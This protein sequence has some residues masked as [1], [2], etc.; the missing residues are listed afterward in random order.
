MNVRS[1]SKKL[2]LVEL[3]D[4]CIE[5]DELC[6]GTG[7]TENLTFRLDLG[8]IRNRTATTFSAGDAQ[9]Y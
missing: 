6:V 8:F 5:S 3:D 2:F 4:F 9:G 7:Q 1:R